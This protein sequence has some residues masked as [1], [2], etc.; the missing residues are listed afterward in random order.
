VKRASAL[1]GEFEIISRYFAPLASGASGA[2]GLLDDAAVIA[3]SPYHELVVKTDAI[4]EGVHFLA[5][6]PPGLIARKALRVNLSDL[7]AKGAIPRAYLMD[8]FLPE[9]VTENWLA[10]FTRGL[11]RDQEEYGIHLIGGDTNSTPGPLT[12]A[13]TALG[14]VRVGR[15]LRRGGATVDDWIYVTGTVGDAAL[16]LAILRGALPEPAAAD[17][18]F[19]TDR[20]RLPRPRVSLGPHLIGL[21]SATIDVSDG[22]AADLGHI[23]DLSRVAAVVEATR[24]PLSAAARVLVGANPE[25]MTT[26]LT[27]G[28]DY[29]IIFTAPQAAVEPLAELARVH[30][31]PITPIGRIV[32]PFAKSEGRVSVAGLD[33]RPMRFDSLGWAH[34]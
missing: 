8:V 34:F 30:D 9:R 27:G 5:G 6:D 23:C 1:P 15:M 22:L 20:Y 33:G 28:D 7:A 29:E 12:V 19:L 17:M 13:I 4:V 16:G 24:L 32:A 2:F 26:M 10:G 21:A 25:L 31:L 14:E 3:P 11:A 18:A